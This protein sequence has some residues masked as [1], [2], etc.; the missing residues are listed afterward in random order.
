MGAELEG[1]EIEIPD[2]DPEGNVE[3][4]GV[5]ME[6]QES[7]PQVIKIGDHNIPRDLILF[8]LKKVLDIPAE[9]EGPTYIS[10]PAIE[11]PCRYIIVRYQSDTYA[12][13]MIGKRYDYAM[14]QLENQG[15]LHPDVN[16]FEHE[17]FYQAK[18]NVVIA[19]MTQ[20]SLKASL[21]EWGDN[22]RSAS[23]S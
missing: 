7:L 12:P 11:G 10:T 14:T 9:T 13:R 18:S 15:V 1:K 6:G 4:P 17:D 20:L 19:I 21:K 23:K 16:M 2:M 5:Y 22:S 3:L 8:A